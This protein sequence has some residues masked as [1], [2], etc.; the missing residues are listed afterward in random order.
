MKLR[1][2]LC[3][4]FT[5][6]LATL[7]VVT[8][9]ACG[10][11]GNKDEK[12]TYYDFTSVSP[13]NWNELTYQD[14]NDTQIMNFIG[15]SFFTFDFEFD[16]EGEIVD[17]GYSIQYEAAKKLEDVTATYAGDD[18]YAVPA[19][20]T[21]NYAYKITLRDD[22][23]WDDGT[24]IKA[25]DFVY[26]MKQQL[27]PLFQNYRADS[28]YTG[29]TVIHNAENYVKQNSD[30]VVSVS[31]VMKNDDITLDE[32]LNNYGTAVS[33]V[34]WDY[35]FGDT[36]VDGKWTG[37]SEDKTV[38]SKLTVKQLY[39]LFIETVTGWG[40][41]EATAKEYFVD[42]AS[43]DY[44]FPELSF[45]KV[46]IFA[47]SK[48]ELVVVLDNPLQLLNEDG[49]LSYYA[50]Y[51]FNSLPLVHKEKFEA[52]KVAPSAGTDLW[53]SKYNSSVETSASWG[54]YKLTEFQ[55]GK[56]YTLERNNKWFGY[57]LKRNK[58]LYQTDVI[59]VETISEYET[60]KMKFLKG[61]LTSI[62][63]DVSVANDYKNSERAIYT[64][65]DYVGAL[66]LQSSYESLKK[67]QREG[68]NKTILSYVE[69]RKAM[70]LAIDRVAYNQTCTT[71]SKAGLGLFN[72]MHYYAVDEGL[73]YRDTDAA[74]KTLCEA[75]SV[76]WTKFD[77]LD[78]AVQSITGYNLTLSK[79]L[80]TEAYNKALAD[81]EISATDKI[82]FIV[83]TSVI[84]EATTRAFNFLK[85]SFEKMLEDTPL[86]GRLVMK[87]QAYD[88]A[89][90]NDFRAGAYEICTGGW[91]G[92]AWD[93][94]YFLL[95]YLSP[96]YMYSAAWDTKSATMKFTAKGAGEGNTDITDTLSLIDWYY[97]LNG[98]NG[99]K[100]N[101]AKGFVSDDVRIELIAALEKEILSVYYTVPIQNH[102]SSALLSYKVE[103]ITYE[104]NTFM[105]YGGIKYMKYNYS[106][107]EWTKFVNQQGGEINY[108]G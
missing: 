34:N 53:T 100:Y 66:Q 51:N 39:D 105:A 12:Y 72:T 19:N 48:Y 49:S 42:E 101:F 10:K 16:S 83:G 52:A 65:D 106:D 94:G 78:K 71:S 86:E 8:L 33:Y 55:A 24:K 99:C 20:A 18:K 54:P 3:S 23:V 91:N 93:P 61:E 30:A 77:S 5:A 36:Y 40:V 82:E 63:I 29:S 68:Y 22:L 67:N 92:A 46:G 21:K 60:Q 102:Y 104:Y 97:C 80:V 45:D 70:S 43:T 59:D 13:S 25:E 62:G 103:Y 73:R 98:A 44:T 88:K 6:V 79:Q 96:A 38:N 50:A 74:K 4:A 32:F 89:W 15:S 14:N 47:P 57:D 81:G 37:S 2:V 17:G 69:F 76:D 27:D 11:D 58:G 75:Y 84:S 9:A 41:D 56:H 95:A 7:T 26:T 35:S 87:E 64:P 107:A 28:F 108:K 85:D 31:T 1:K 90:A